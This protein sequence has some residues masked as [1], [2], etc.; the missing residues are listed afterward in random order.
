MKHTAPYCNYEEKDITLD[1]VMSTLVLG[2]LIGGLGFVIIDWRRSSHAVCGRAVLIVVINDA[3]LAL[4]LSA[5]SLWLLTRLRRARRR[6]ATLAT[7]ACAGGGRSRG[8]LP[9]RT[10]Y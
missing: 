4:S 10:V 9:G 1:I 8:W 6:A 7:R 2:S 3:L 5:R